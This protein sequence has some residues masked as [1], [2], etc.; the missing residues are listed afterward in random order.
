MARRPY[1]TTVFRGWA[2]E[3]PP[4]CG[5]LTSAH[6]AGQVAADAANAAVSGDFALLEVE[7]TPDDLDQAIQELML[8]WRGPEDSRAMDTICEVHSPPGW[9][10]WRKA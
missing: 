5:N 9:W 3:V 7:T 4:G 6:V 10:R 8:I 1:Q 2:P